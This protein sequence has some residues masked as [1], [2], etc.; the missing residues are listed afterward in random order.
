MT[1]LLDQIGGPEGL[2]RVVDDFVE[3]MLRDAMIGFHFS[4]VDAARLKVLE[5]QFAAVALGGDAP[6]QGRP[7][8]SA[9]ARHPISGGQF[10]RR[11]EILRQTLED[12]GVAAE[13]RQGW[14]EHTE[15][16]RQA[17]VRGPQDRCGV[18]G[19][20]GALLTEVGADGAEIAPP[21]SEG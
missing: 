4:G 12:H 14:L 2:Q 6:Y 8:R 9:H 18:A 19:A 21:V 7:V 15:R 1:T 3:R 16:L 5:A 13:V 10:S 20:F 11:K 17:I